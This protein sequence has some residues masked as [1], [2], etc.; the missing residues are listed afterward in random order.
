[1][2]SRNSTGQICH[3][4]KGSRQRAAVEQKWHQQLLCT[5][6]NHALGGIL[7]FQDYVQAT[8]IYNDD[9]LVLVSCVGDLQNCN[10][11]R[12]NSDFLV[13]IAGI[14]LILEALT[15]SADWG[16]ASLCVQLCGGCRAVCV[17]YT[18]NVLILK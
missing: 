5:G 13:C 2:G 6:Q 18:S 8:V 3:I 1:M 10:T 17:G 16:V 12:T 9:R 14:C 4:E 7:S 15:E 11:Q